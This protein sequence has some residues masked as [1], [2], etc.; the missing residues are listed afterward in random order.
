MKK[1]IVAIFVGIGLLGC[2]T[3]YYVH[4]KKIAAINY[5]NQI[6][7]DIK[8]DLQTWSYVRSNDVNIKKNYSRSIVNKLI[9]VV[10]LK[11][12]V[13]K[14]DGNS[15]ETICLLRATEYQKLI[16]LYDVN[17]HAKLVLMYL[18]DIREDSEIGLK[19]LQKSLGG[20]GCSPVK[21]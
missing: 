5:S 6:L 12:E 1:I 21:T 3:L 20:S 8:D 16:E 17:D 19:K 7:G 15:L 14:L 9:R 11:P 13:V 2:L 4:N 10:I 18:D